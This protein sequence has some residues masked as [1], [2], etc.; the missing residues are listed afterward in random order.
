MGLARLWAEKRDGAK[1]AAILTLNKAK[2]I[3]RASESAAANAHTLKET[4][5]PLHKLSAN[6]PTLG[7]PSMSPCRH[8]CRFK[9]ASCHACG[10]LGHIAPI[11]RSKNSDYSSKLKKGE[12]P[13]STSLTALATLQLSQPARNLRKRSC[14]SV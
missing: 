13:G 14:T 2:Q 6:A 8:S 7:R 9:S 1:E 12:K 4:E 10:K 11:C 3:A 5:V